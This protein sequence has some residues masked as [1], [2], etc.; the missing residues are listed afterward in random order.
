MMK[1]LHC[2]FSL[3]G[4]GAERQLLILALQ[5]QNCGIESAIFCVSDD[6]YDDTIDHLKIY[7]PSS[8]GPRTKLRLFFGI[9][10]AI[11]DFQPDVVHAW[12]PP[13]I[14]IPTLVAAKLE[15]I[16]CVTSYRNR[17]FFDTFLRRADFVFQ[18][19]FSKKIISNNPVDQSSPF[20]RWLYR[21]K[22]G[23]TISNAMDLP[24]EYK[25]KA[26]K[27]RNY[28]RLIF[29]GRLTRQKNLKVVIE[30]IAKLGASC[31]F[32]LDV[33]GAG[34][35]ENELKKLVDDLSL[36][37]VIK[38]RG[39]VDNIYKEMSDGGILILPSLYE[40]MPNVLIEAMACGLPALCADI[41]SVRFLL[42]SGEEVICFDP[43]DADSL[44][45]ILEKIQKSEIDLQRI[46]EKGFNLSDKFDANRMIENYSA[47]YGGIVD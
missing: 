3:K 45:A 35:R 18:F 39:Y 14:T 7:K 6:A 33:F 42:E 40:G 20:F 16:P 47:V 15:G 5:S 17:M 43:N 32:R 38:F 19:I 13:I 1:V 36:N 26:L 10:S 22:D 28:R 24:A 31:E 27:V 25:G 44:V 21:V 11:R 34:E 41:P 12:L 23:S 8:L 9:K 46:S 4:G 37:G 30:A 2:I 29:V